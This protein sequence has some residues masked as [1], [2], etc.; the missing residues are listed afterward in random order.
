MLCESARAFVSSSEED[1]Q[2]ED[3]NEAYQDPC[4]PI[5][6]D[7]HSEPP[8]RR[9]KPGRHQPGERALPTAGR[10]ESNLKQTF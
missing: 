2:G 4:K 9:V 1:E 3:H 5:L 7:K 6:T 8:Y 10:F